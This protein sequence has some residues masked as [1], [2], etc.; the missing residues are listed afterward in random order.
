MRTFW[1]L[2]RNAATKVSKDQMKNLFANSVQLSKQGEKGLTV[3]HS[4]WGVFQ[5]QTVLTICPVSVSITDD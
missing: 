3:N 4:F 5:S 2:I 1:C